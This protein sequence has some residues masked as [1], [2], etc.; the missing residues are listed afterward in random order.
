[1]SKL[2][3][4]GIER[5]PPPKH[6]PMKIPVIRGADGAGQEFGIRATAQPQGSSSVDLPMAGAREMILLADAG[7]CRLKHKGFSQNDTRI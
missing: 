2:T 1:M 6:G 7:S 5:R 4:C 3:E